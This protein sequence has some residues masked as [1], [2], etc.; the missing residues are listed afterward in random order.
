[1]KLCIFGPRFTGVVYPYTDKLLVSIDPIQ[2]Y[3]QENGLTLL[4]NEKC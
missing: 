3:V 4:K 2:K 1:V